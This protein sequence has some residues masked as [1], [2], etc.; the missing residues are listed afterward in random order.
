MF[1]H[2]NTTINVLKECSLDILWIPTRSYKRKL[3]SYIYSVTDLSSNNGPWRDNMSNFYNQ[4]FRKPVFFSNNFK[5][6]LSRNDISKHPGQCTL[7]KEWPFLIVAEALKGRSWKGCL[8][9]HRNLFLCGFQI[10]NF[11][12][13]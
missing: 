12:Q 10:G 2:C 7:S 6:I 8:L 9:H 1:L 3:L 13:L 11:R 4:L 5:I